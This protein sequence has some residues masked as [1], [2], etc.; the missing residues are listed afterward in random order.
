[1]PGVSRESENFG[2][3]PFLRFLPVKFFSAIAVGP[4][5]TGVILTIGETIIHRV[6]VTLYILF[7]ILYL[8][9]LNR[10]RT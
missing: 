4:G 2:F 5:D 9:A 7:I 8:L 10:G 1:M 3:R 6:P